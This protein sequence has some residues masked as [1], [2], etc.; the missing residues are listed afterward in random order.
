MYTDVC[1]SAAWVLTECKRLRNDNVCPGTRFAER[2][3]N[4]NPV[5]IK[6]EQVG[7]QKNKLR[8]VSHFN[9]K[10]R[11]SRPQRNNRNRKKE[12]KS[13]RKSEWDN[14]KSG[15]VRSVSNMKQSGSGIVS[16]LSVSEVCFDLRSCWLEPYTARQTVHDVQQDEAFD[17]AR[18]HRT[19]IAFYCY[20][21]RKNEAARQIFAVNFTGSPRWLP[22]VMLVLKYRRTHLLFFFV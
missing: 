9:M 11:S 1:M 8:R 14:R 20:S 19:V 5:V 10:R 6:L 2:V 21:S 7:S 18:E 3:R 16:H 17:R 12:E 15:C 4:S 13:T 22:H